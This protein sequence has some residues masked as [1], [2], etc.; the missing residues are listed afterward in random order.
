MDVTERLLGSIRC[1]RAVSFSPGQFLL[2]AKALS[3][4]L[5]PRKGERNHK[6]R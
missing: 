2:I 6:V 3:Q 4:T 1:Y 5:S